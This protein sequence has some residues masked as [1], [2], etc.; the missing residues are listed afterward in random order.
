[1]FALLVAGTLLR[2][3][4]PLFDQ[5]PYQFWIAL[6]GCCWMFPSACFW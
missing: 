2:V 4:L 3:L 5:V 6:A 1:M